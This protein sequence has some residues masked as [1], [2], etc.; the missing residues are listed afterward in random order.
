MSAILSDATAAIER[1]ELALG[2]EL[3]L[4][5]V[6]RDPGNTAAW[7]WLARTC[8]DPQRRRECL[9]QVLALDPD[10]DEALELLTQPDLRPGLPGDAGSGHSVRAFWPAIQ[11]GLGALLLLTG[12]FLP[13]L[14]VPSVGQVSFWQIDRLMSQTYGTLLVGMA[15]LSLIFVVVSRF[16]WLWLTGLASFVLL[17]NAFAQLF[18]FQ[19]RLTFRDIHWLGW[20]VMFPGAILLIMVAARTSRRFT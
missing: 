14:D 16:K 12:A 4:Q 10:N 20:L 18:A 7:L 11:G 19:N 15:L 1:G 6:S 3:L 9:E 2:R 5:I 13:I 17:A 8:H